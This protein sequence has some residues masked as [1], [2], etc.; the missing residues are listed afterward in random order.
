[1]SSSFNLQCH[2]FP[3]DQNPLAIALTASSRQPSRGLIFVTG[4]VEAEAMGQTSFY[5]PPFCD[6]EMPAALFGGVE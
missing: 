2:F 6:L 5:D 3:R 4:N 1:M